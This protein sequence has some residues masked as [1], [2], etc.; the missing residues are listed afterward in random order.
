MRP[1]RRMPAA[2]YVVQPA[3]PPAANDPP[4]EALPIADGAT[5]E[6]PAAQSSPVE[7]PAAETVQADPPFTELLPD[8]T[9]QDAESFFAGSPS[10]EPLPEAGQVNEALCS[11]PPVTELLPGAEQTTDS[12][13]APPPSDEVLPAE[14][15]AATSGHQRPGTQRR[16]TGAVQYPQDSGHAVSPEPVEMLPAAP[17]PDA[18][19]LPA[20]PARPV[21]RPDEIEPLPLPDGVEEAPAV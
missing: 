12:L 7:S 11:P 6:P 13:Y 9:P 1:V 15:P 10:T 14:V 17:L 20:R 21:S 16:V 2:Q 5:P 8:A 4:A 3:D 18:T 19:E